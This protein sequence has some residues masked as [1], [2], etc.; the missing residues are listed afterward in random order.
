MSEEF[1]D[2]ELEEP[3]KGQYCEI[4]VVSTF[5]G[6]YLPECKTWSWVMD[7]EIDPVSHVESW[8]PY[9]EKE[10]IFTWIASE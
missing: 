6:W 3:H 4:R 1:I 10:D 9:N 7:D 8:R 2:I 5:R